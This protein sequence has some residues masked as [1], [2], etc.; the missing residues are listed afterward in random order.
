MLTEHLAT[1][2]TGSRPASIRLSRRSYSTTLTA[3]ARLRQWCVGM[4]TKRWQSGRTALGR[5]PSSGL[6]PYSASSGCSNVAGDSAIA[7]AAN[8]TPAFHHNAIIP[9]STKTCLLP[10]AQAAAVTRP[11]N[12]RGCIRCPVPQPCELP[13]FVGFVDVLGYKAIVRGST[14]TDAQR[15]HYLH[16]IF[17]ALAVWRCDPSTRRRIRSLLTDG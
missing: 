4:T 9:I 1:G 5:P 2:P 16:S 15:F 6:N 13:R 10:A 11:A 3:A 7:A 17:S 8:H 14:F 12:N